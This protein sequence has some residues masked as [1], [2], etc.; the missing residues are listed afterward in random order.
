MGRGRLDNAQFGATTMIF[1][2]N[3]REIRIALLVW[4]FSALT[5]PAF[6]LSPRT[7]VS[8]LGNDANSC[9]TTALACRTFQRAHNETTP[10]GEVNVLDGASYGDLTITK[11]ISIVNDSGGTALVQTG[12]TAITINAGASDA[13]H[14]R[15]IT[16]LGLNTVFHGVRLDAGGSLDIV[17][18]V[19]RKVNSGVIAYTNVSTPWR[20]SVVNTTITDSARAI[21]IQPFGSGEVRGAIDGLI[22]GKNSFGLHFGSFQPP[23]ARF[24]VSVAR[25]NISTNVTGVHVF[26][27]GGA[28]VPKVTV[29]DSTIG[30]NEGTGVSVSNGGEVSLARS[31]VV[32]NNVGAQIAT[33]GTI[34]SMRDNN[35][36]LNNSDG[37]ALT[38]FAPN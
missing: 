35:F 24:N 13:I 27:G 7:F 14:L 21:D 9:A 16:I 6:A 20:F 1:Q 29:Q 11:A 23:A 38:P 34:F 5:A 17:N 4:G 33:G 28:A 10:G 3:A 30:A 15:G 32:G 19:I 8:G 31:N 36:A 2:R 37:V 12:G 25:S 22:A 26:S 18:C